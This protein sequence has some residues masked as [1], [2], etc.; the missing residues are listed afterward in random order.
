MASIPAFCQQCNIAFEDNA[1][2]VT[3]SKIDMGGS[4]TTCPRCGGR[5]KLVDGSFV[6]KGKGLEI[7]AAPPETHAV[8]EALFGVAEKVKS[9]EITDNQAVKE[10][11]GINPELAK[12][13]NL[14]VSLGIPLIGIFV[15]V[16]G[17]YMQAEGNA[18]TAEFQKQSL[19]LMN[20]QV[21]LLKQ[22]QLVETEPSIVQTAPESTEQDATVPIPTKR[23][24]TK[25]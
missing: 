7:V 16:I 1:I 6:E 23:P 5:A 8:F 11:E 25:S 13:F 2:V 21:E 3:N 24:D 12:T 22:L 9:G 4:T 15:A 10:V 17:F 20:E 14:F 19:E 18:S